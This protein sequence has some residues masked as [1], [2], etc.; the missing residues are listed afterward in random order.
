MNSIL[1]LCHGARDIPGK[2]VLLKRDMGPGRNNDNLLAKLKSHGFYLCVPNA[3]HVQG[4][5]YWRIYG[6]PAGVWGRIFD[7]EP[8]LDHERW[9]CVNAIGNVGSLPF[10]RQHLQ[11]D[12]ACHEIIANSDGVTDAGANLEAS[13]YLDVYR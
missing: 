6:W 9:I 13:F 2:I 3:T 8:Y 4:N 5:S 10:T 11:D 1:P 12:N 7:L